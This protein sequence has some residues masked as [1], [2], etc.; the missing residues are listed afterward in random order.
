M[1]TDT[2]KGT[3][4]CALIHHEVCVCGYC[5]C[6]HVGGYQGRRG[7]VRYTWPGGGADLP[8]N[9]KPTQRYA[10]LVRHLRS[11]EEISA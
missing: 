10:A 3:L 9:H 1:G 2:T 6:A 4:G 5:R 11:L 8:A 7:C